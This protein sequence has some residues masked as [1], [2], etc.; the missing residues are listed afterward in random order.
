MSSGKERVHQ[1]MA[2]WTRT[3]LP[4]RMKASLAGQRSKRK[5]PGACGASAA[6]GRSGWKVKSK[7]CRTSIGLSGMEC[8]VWEN[9]GVTLRPQNEPTESKRQLFSKERW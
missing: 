3:S 1:I 8:K 7:A 2:R 4:K 6:K 5:K 9:G